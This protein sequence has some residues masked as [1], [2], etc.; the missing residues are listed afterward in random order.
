MRTNFLLDPDVIFLNHGSF[1]ATPRPVFEAYQTWQRRLER[2]PVQFLAGDLT[3]HLVQARQALGDYLNVTADDLVY[4]PNATYGVNV[5][6]RSLELGP[7]DEVL[8]TNQEYGACWRTWHFLAQERGFAVREVAWPWPLP[9]PE[10][11]VAQFMAAVTP[12]TKLIF[13]SHITSTTAVVL[14]VA[15]ICARARALSILTLV[16]GAHAPGQIE[17]DITAVGA[18]FY[19]GNCHK[20]LC[21]PKG[22]AFLYTHPNC[23]PLIKPLIV[24]WGWGANRPFTFGSDYL[25]YMQWTGTNDPAAYLTVPTAIDFQAGHDWPT[26]RAR[27]AAL[28]QAGLDEVSGL[29]GLPSPYAGVRAGYRPPQMGLLPLPVEKVV[30]RGDT[31]VFKQIL[32]DQFHIEIPVLSW[33]DQRFVRLSVQA[34]TT[35]KDVQTLVEA[36]GTLLS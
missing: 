1:G 17:L 2:Q 3:G 32:Y 25:D 15:D 12:N 19:T 14:P 16:D 4:V 5:V 29:T 23:Q 18:D 7:G 34:Y 24:S 9:A 26:V 6:A 8:M 21:A 33:H 30:E 27:C 22:A 10:E 13:L 36:L 35:Q 11:L 31:A 20:W 28:L